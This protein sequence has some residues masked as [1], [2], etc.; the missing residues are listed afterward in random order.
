VV[1]WAVN[2]TLRV[3]V[4]EDDGPI[5][6]AVLYCLRRDGM[7]AEVAPTLAAARLATADAD[8][9]VLDLGLPDGSGFT[10]LP[11]IRKIEHGPRVIVLTSRDEDVECVAALEA[12][13]DDFV[14]KPFSPRALA[15]RVRAVARRGERREDA[16]RPEDRAPGLLVDAERRRASFAG[17]ELA[18]TKIELDLLL[19]LAEAPGRV[20]TRDYLVT[21]V[22]GDEYALAERTVDSHFKG[23]RRK[24]NEAG[25]PATLVETV[26]G[27]GFTLRERA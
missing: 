12:G 5:A 20:R 9:V 24:L 2:H 13:A 26:R 4:V 11:E 14:T 6:D 18:L 7:Q 3:L 8:V 23:L 25:A 22:W 21:R 19:V 27:V 16:P 15:A 1:S 10:L 17:K